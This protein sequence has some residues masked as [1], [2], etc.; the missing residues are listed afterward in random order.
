MGIGPTGKTVKWTGI[1]IL[2]FEQGRCVERWNEGD[3]LGL[4]QQ[5]GAIPSS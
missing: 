5:L 4:T 3:Y 1:T 2:R